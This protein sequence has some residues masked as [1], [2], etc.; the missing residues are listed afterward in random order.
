MD[1]HDVQDPGHHQE[2]DWLSLALR[3]KA[4]TLQEAIMA[5]PEIV[6]LTREAQQALDAARRPFAAL[7]LRK[8]IPATGAVQEDLI[9]LRWV[10]DI[11]R[12]GALPKGFFAVDFPS[13]DSE[14]FYCWTYP[15]STIS[16]QH[17]AWETFKD[18]A[19]ISEKPSTN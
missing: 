1:Q 4:F 6:R 9:R 5:L 2:L 17:K 12:L 10:Q 7:G 11:A 18:R 13:R 3:P 19:P 8:W 14:T 15:E 16:Y